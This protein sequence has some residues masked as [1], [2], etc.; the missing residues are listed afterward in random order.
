MDVKAGSIVGAV[1]SVECVPSVTFVAVS[2]ME[3][4][5]GASVGASVAPPV[6]FFSKS[7]EN[8]K[9]FSF[10]Q[11]VEVEFK[12]LVSGSRCFCARKRDMGQK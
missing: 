1:T 5:V 6:F 4:V 3:A 12:N 2:V 10:R 11:G 9:N 8:K 7:N